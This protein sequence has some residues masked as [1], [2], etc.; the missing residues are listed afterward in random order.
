[1]FSISSTQGSCTD[2]GL[3]YTG[4]ISLHMS[5]KLPVTSLHQCRAGTIAVAGNLGALTLA[6]TG[7]GTIFTSGLAAGAA[8]AVSGSGKTIVLPTGGKSV[9]QPV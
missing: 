4:C 5:A 9:V 1:M 6:N 3:D 2:T 7:T 8:A